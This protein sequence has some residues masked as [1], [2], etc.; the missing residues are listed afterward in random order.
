MEINKEFIIKELSHY[1]EYDLTNLLDIDNGEIVKI[2]NEHC[3]KYSETIEIGSLYEESET[4]PFLTETPDGWQM[5]GDLIKKSP[6]N[7]LKFEMANG[8]IVSVSSDHLFETPKGWIKSGELKEKDLIL[9]KEGFIEIKSILESGI[10]DV[11]DWEILHENH[12]YWSS[13]ISSHNTGKSFFC[14]NVVREAQKIGYDVIYCDT[15]GAIDKSGALKF[16]IDADK[17]RYQPIQTVSQ[18]QTFASNVIDAVK[19]AKA[20]GQKPKVLLVLDSLGMLSTDKELADAM[21]GHN[22]ADMGAKAKELRKLFRVITLDLTAAKIP[23][24]CTNHVYCLTAGH[25]ILMSDGS[26]KN[27]E[28]IKI[29]DMVKTLDGDKNITSVFEFD[30]KDVVKLTLENGQT[31]ECTPNHRFLVENEYTDEKSWKC[32]EDLEEGDSIL[33]ID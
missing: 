31:I 5:V 4:C 22:A 14:L 28:N 26:Y 17:L 2:F 6:R 7:I 21:K 15:E 23:L 8:F 9:T 16:G 1:S 25:K 20:A 12:R 27:I 33:Q 3:E 19:K 18:F 11:Y 24:L 32:A 10:E 13:G 29:G 30:E